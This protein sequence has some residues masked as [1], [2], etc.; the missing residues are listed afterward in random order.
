[1]SDYDDD[2][3]MP[4]AHASTYLA[5]EQRISEQSEAIINFKLEALE[6]TK[7][8]AIPMLEKFSFREWDDFMD[9]L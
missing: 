2:E 7:M 4:P 5:N 1:M 8:Y 3:Y 9:N 6:W